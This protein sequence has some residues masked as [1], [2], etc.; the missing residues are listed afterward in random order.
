MS[1]Q[2][3]HQLKSNLSLASEQQKYRLCSGSHANERL[4]NHH[5]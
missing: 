2:I 1:E 4:I 5:D 3:I